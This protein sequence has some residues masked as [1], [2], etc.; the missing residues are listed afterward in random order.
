MS[1]LHGVQLVTE[2]ICNLCIWDQDSI[3]E[4]GVPRHTG[5][6]Q[7]MRKCF[8]RAFVISNL[9][10][11]SSPRGRVTRTGPTAPLRHLVVY[12]MQCALFLGD[13]QWVALFVSYGTEPY[14]LLVLICYQGVYKSLNDIRQPPP[15]LQPIMNSLRKIVSLRSLR[16]LPLRSSDRDKGPFYTYSRA[17]S[18][19]TV[20]CDILPT[21]DLY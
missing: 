14:D 19:R 9:L 10:D 17:R 21:S 12:A 4:T 6:P 2:A 13:V 16:S 7:G 1:S 20:H 3:T 5:S 15:Y 8:R 18:S 11:Q